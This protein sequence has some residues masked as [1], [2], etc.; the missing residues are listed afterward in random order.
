MNSMVAR[1]SSTF[2]APAKSVQT[3]AAGLVAFGAGTLARRISLYKDHFIIDFLDTALQHGCFCG[4][5]GV[6]SLGFCVL[7]DFLAIKRIY[8]IIIWRFFNGSFLQRIKTRKTGLLV[9]AFLQRIFFNKTTIKRVLVPRAY[10]Q[11]L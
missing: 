6:V 11:H 3:N 9:H 5:F 10:L 7:S 8:R 4:M 2:I 1:Q